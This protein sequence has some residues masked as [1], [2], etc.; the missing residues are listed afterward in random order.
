MGA[1]MARWAVS[2]NGID[3]GELTGG[4]TDGAQILGGLHLGGSGD[5]F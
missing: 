5:P 2:G 3:I 4:L 1:D